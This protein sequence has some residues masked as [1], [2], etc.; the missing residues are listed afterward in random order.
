MRRRKMTPPV[1][2]FAKFYFLKLTDTLLHPLKE[3]PVPDFNNLYDSTI[4]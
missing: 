3:I 1:L 2:L 4:L